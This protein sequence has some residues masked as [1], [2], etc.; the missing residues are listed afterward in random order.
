MLLPWGF[1]TG[2]SAALATASNMSIS[3]VRLLS[4]SSHLLQKLLT[5][6]HLKSIQPIRND[7]RYLMHRSLVRRDVLRRNAVAEF[8]LHRMVYKAIHRDQRLDMNTRLK[9]MMALDSFHAYT[10]PSEIKARCV[11]TGWAQ[12][13]VRGWRVNR[14]VFR[15]NA[16]H[17]RLPGVTLAFQEEKEAKLSKKKS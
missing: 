6:F 17:G 12:G 15:D 9:A 7:H 16:I 4:P 14:N 5:T 2:P 3:G 13:L 1:S 8:E 11:E 10:R